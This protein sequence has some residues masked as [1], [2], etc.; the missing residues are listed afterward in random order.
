MMAL[1]KGVRVASWEGK[2]R[3]KVVFSFLC[4]CVCV[5][6]VCGERGTSLG[7]DDYDKLKKIGISREL[8]NVAGL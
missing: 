3:T 4:V 1:K 8:P 5:V 2:E 6:V 7:S